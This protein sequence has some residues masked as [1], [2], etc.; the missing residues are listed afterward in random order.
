MQK[1]IFELLVTSKPEVLSINKQVLLAGGHEDHQEVKC[2]QSGLADS[3]YAPASDQEEV[4]TRMI[5]HR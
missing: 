3:L 1:F 4:D 2:I 5:L